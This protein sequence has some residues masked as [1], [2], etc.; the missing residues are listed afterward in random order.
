MK[1]TVFTPTYNRGYLLDKLY[2]SLIVQTNKDFEWFIV[3]DG[4]TDNTRDIVKTFIDD[5]KIQIRYLYQENGGK[6]R[7]INKGLDNVNSELFF[8]VDSDDILISS[9]IEIILE[10]FKTIEGS[11]EFA[12]I[13][14]NRGYSEREMIGNT[15]SSYYIDCTNL[16]RGKNNILGDKSEIYIT[17][18][19]RK[20]KFPEIEGEN[21]MS[22]VVLWNEIARQGYK[23][24]W[25]N[26]II[27]ICN[28]LE[29][30]L[31]INRNSIYKKNPIAH[32]MMVREFLQIDVSIK[33]K[34]MEIYNYFIIW[35]EEKS[36]KEIAL[37]LNI[38]RVVL[39]SC[40]MLVQVRE[41]IRRK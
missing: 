41:I 10:K 3:D 29:D 28:Y 26:E 21:F 23:L 24:R 27:Y 11:I 38:S 17:E 40:I 36:I 20:I 8:I 7:A 15:F 16:E 18:I 31:T 37:D 12:G 5:N 6:H 1:I 33:S 25:F 14:F 19:L 35:K 39:S 32:K 2:K 34:I 4:S 13:G 22:E 9:A 30:G